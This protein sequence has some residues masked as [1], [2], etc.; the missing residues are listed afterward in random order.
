[1]SIKITTKENQRAFEVCDLKAYKL[2][3]KRWGG[4][5]YEG[6]GPL[7]LGAAIARPLN[8]MDRVRDRDTS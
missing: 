2:K 8:V 5:D 3:D 7:W 6:D 1:M 4:Y